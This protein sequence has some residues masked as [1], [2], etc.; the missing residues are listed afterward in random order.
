MQI[1]RL[2][3]QN[4]KCLQ[5]CSITFEK[6]TLIMGENNA[7]KSAF[8][9]ALDT[10]FGSE[11]SLDADDYFQRRVDE[12]V[13]ISVTFYNLTDQEQR[14]FN[15]HSRDGEITISREFVYGEA[16]KEAAKFY[17]EAQVFSGFEEI[18]A[19]KSDAQKKKLY[20]DL[21]AKMPSGLLPTVSKGGDIEEHLQNWE[22]SNPDKLTTVRKGRAF[23]FSNVALGKLRGATSFHLIPAVQDASEE[24]DSEK[25]SPV[26]QLVSDIVKQTIE[27]QKEFQIFKDDAVKKL[28]QLTSPGNVPSLHRIGEELTNIVSKY[29]EASKVTADISPVSELPISFPK[30]KILVEDNEFVSSIENLGHGLQRAVLMSV[31]EFLASQNAMGQSGETF[32]TVQSDIVIAI[33][34]PEIYQ[35]PVKQRLFSQALKRLCDGFNEQNGIRFQVIVVTHSP[36]FLEIR[37]AHNIRLVRRF[38]ANGYS[39]PAVSGLSLAECANATAKFLGY[40]PNLE[41][42]AV[43]LHTFSYDIAEGLFSKATIFVEGESDKAFINGFLL[44]RGFDPLLKGVTIAPTNGKT[45]L[46]KPISI[47]RN[48][49]LDCF[50][51]AD[52]DRFERKKIRD[53]KKLNGLLQHLFEISDADAL[54]YPSGYKNRLLFMEGDLE[55][56]AQQCVG[57]SRYSEIATELAD[58][59]DTPLSECKKSPYFVAQLF[60]WF[61]SEKIQFSDLEAF[62]DDLR[63]V[64]EPRRGSVN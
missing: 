32:E 4:Y 3:V 63:Q 57:E 1:K 16:K 53:N 38:V 51:V 62:L 27:N 40:E 35:H 49:N 12:P 34:E 10:F 19:E 5:D 52:N 55:N 2:H 47:F 15:D 6:L 11:T 25:S 45:N 24:I 26:R 58:A 28:E 56:Y 46:D 48:L 41:K 31:I 61:Q 60:E 20:R 14:E 44:S 50:V 17:S 42:Y 29:Y 18:R 33:E 23:G 39:Y 7:G 22:A 43:K 36:L 64:V 9:K 54:E 37:E 13:L 8:L 21:T 59:F 30:P